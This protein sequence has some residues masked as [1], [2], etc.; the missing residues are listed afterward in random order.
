MEQPDGLQTELLKMSRPARQWVLELAAARAAESRVLERI[1]KHRSA[2]DA[3]LA[4]MK[5]PPMLSTG[6]R[7]DRFLLG[8]IVALELI[9]GEPT[10]PVEGMA[11]DAA[12]AAGG[13][14]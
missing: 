12:P 8:L 1:D 14:E 10:I 7:G 3:F 13:E 9:R 2:R 5:L 4:R 6:E 11:D